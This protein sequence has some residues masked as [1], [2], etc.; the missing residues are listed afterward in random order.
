MIFIK[1]RETGRTLKY[2]LLSVTLAVSLFVTVLAGTT[3]CNKEEA[4]TT[5]APQGPSASAP[6]NAPG[7]SPEAQAA[8]QAQ[9]K[10]ESESRAAHAPPAPK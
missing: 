3:G 7:L 9:Q 4:A 10:A 6:Q 1:F 8:M 2:T 5:N